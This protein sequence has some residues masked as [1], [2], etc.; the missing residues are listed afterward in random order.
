[1]SEPPVFSLDVRP[2]AGRTTI[3]VAGEIDM[4]TAPEF[5]AGVV[6]QLDGAK[7]VLDLRD[8]EF[9]DSSG[10]S[11]LDALLKEADR[12]GADLSLLRELRPPVARV[13]EITGMMETLPL[14]EP[15]T[16]S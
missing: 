15:G 12:R 8:V 2:D 9:I 1:M 4:V 11:A 14:A 6:D 10:V 16:S 7:L 13:L 3:V 5:Q